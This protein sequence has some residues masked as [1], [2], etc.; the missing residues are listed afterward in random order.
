[1]INFLFHINRIKQFSIFFFC[2]HLFPLHSSCPANQSTELDYWHT[3]FKFPSN[4][5]LPAIHTV[6]F[7]VLKLF[8]P[9]NIMSAVELSKVS[10]LSQKP[11][12]VLRSSRQYPS[13]YLDLVK[14][15]IKRKVCEILNMKLERSLFLFE[16]NSEVHNINLYP[17][18]MWL[19]YKMFVIVYPYIVEVIHRHSLSNTLPY[20]YALSGQVRNIQCGSILLQ[21]HRS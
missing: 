14:L 13:Q 21:C 19:L 6:H 5:L 9:N 1:L 4:P 11:T 18:K 16:F 2:I 10:S 3:L 17:Q 20:T 8:T 12:P 15:T 7:P